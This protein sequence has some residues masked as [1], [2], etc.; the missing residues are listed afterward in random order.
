MG[1]TAEDEFTGLMGLMS[2]NSSIKSHE[3]HSVCGRACPPV[4]L[5]PATL[6]RSRSLKLS[7]ESGFHI[8]GCRGSLF[9]NLYA[10]SFLF[11][12]S[13][14]SDVRGWVQEGTGAYR[15]CYRIA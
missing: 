13:V 11:V 12:V 3:S 1:E 10:T 9:M 2:R 7:G 8:A 15:A 5:G 4:E 6:H 14:A